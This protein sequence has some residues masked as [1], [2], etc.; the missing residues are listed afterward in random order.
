M[1]VAEGFLR[2]SF[3][4]V[5]ELFAQQKFGAAIGTIS[6]PISQPDASISSVA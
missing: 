2:I 5:S 3:D 4:G 6:R 1:N